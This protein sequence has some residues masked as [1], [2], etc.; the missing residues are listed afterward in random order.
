MIHTA[1]LLPK[2][3]DAAGAN[4]EM[5]EVAVKIAWRRAAGSG[6]R[7]HAVPFRLYHKTLTVS[8]G[9]AIWQRQLQPMGAELIFRINKMLRRNVVDS[10]EFRIDPGTLSRE[11]LEPLAK[12]TT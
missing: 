7:R 9:D 8:V 1:L 11:N 10:I 6:L 5:T 12:T 4:Q 3:L 2:I